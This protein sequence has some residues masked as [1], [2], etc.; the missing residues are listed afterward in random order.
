MSTADVL[1]AARRAADAWRVPGPRPDWHRQ[2]QRSVELVWS[3]LAGALR[4]LCDA[5]EAVEVGDLPDVLG[6]LDRAVVERAARVLAPEHWTNPAEFYGFGRPGAE[7]VADGA[8]RREQ[9]REAARDLARRALTAALDAPQ[10]D[11]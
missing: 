10:T 7:R 11:A 5:V 6:S 4:G 9:R 3:T 1:A 2:Q 8:P